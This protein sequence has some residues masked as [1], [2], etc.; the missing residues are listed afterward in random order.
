MATHMIARRMRL[1]R[2]GKGP[3]AGRWDPQQLIEEVE[4]NLDT[5]I[6][7]VGP[8]PKG[9]INYVSPPLSGS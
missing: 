5:H 7:D 8:I 2:E 4:E 3:F 6:L 1:L 9:Y